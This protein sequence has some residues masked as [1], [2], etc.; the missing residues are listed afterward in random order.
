MRARYDAWLVSVR[1][2]GARVEVLDAAPRHAAV[3]SLPGADERLPFALAE[4]GPVPGEPGGRSGPA[5]LVCQ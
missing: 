5:G 3:G 2:A 4:L 1:A